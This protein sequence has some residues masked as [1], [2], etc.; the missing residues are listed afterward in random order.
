MIL[1]DYAL[2][3]VKKCSCELVQCN[4]VMQPLTR[5]L[6]CI[7]YESIQNQNRKYQVI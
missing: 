2:W 3:A 4:Q 1:F 5:L 7:K 6:S